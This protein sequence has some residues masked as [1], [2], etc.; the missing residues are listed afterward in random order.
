M[1]SQSSEAG[2]ETIVFTHEG[3]VQLAE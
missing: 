2:I 1:N 3:M